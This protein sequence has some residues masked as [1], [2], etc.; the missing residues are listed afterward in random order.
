MFDVLMLMLHVAWYRFVNVT[1]VGST[2][3]N[4]YF[5]STRRS[6]YSFVLSL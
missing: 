2:T 5:F 4:Y 1:G 3:P 6:E